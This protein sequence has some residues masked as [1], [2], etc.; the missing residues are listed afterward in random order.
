[1]QKSHRMLAESPGVANTAGS[2][3]TAPVG[4]GRGRIHVRRRSVTRALEGGL[5][6]SPLTERL[7]GYH[8][9]FTGEETEAQRGSVS[10][11]LNPGRSASLS[12]LQRETVRTQ[13]GTQEIAPTPMNDAIF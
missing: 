1:M 9:C 3:L 11:D 6:R 2:Q 7:L 5:L 13:Q 10:Q 4:T 12:V 8:L